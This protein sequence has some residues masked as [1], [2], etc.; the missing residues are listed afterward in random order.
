MFVEHTAAED[1]IYNY[2]CIP[3]MKLTIQLHTTG[4]GTRSLL[5]LLPQA[6]LR[7][8]FHHNYNS[9]VGV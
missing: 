5:M 9:A 4:H 3:L 7:V 6:G 2:R 8:N 1:E